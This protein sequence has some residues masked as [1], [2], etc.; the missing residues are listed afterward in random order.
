V[1]NIGIRYAL[2]GT[3]SRAG[4][5]T[6]NGVTTS[7]TFPATG[8]FTTWA[9]LRVNATLSNNSTNVV[10][11]ASTGADL[12]NIDYLNIPP[13]RNPADVYPAE[14]ATRG[15]TT[16]CWV[17]TTNTGFNVTGYIN[18]T[19]TTSTLTLSS[20]NPDGGGTRAMTIRYALRAAGAR[21]GAL[22]VDGVNTAI[23]FQPAG[24]WPTWATMTVNLTLSATGTNTIQFTST[25]ADLANVDEISI[26]W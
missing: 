26:P 10:R 18:F 3:A 9:T 20:V 17:E 16:P 24:A 2:A 4:T 6:V 8:A 11:F 25:G 19:A 7:I 1:K 12:A 23:T 14:N 15:S 21:T 5:L 13:T 22:T